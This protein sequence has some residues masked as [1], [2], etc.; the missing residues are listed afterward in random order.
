MRL[1]LV[2]WAFCAAFLAVS[3][4]KRDFG[5]DARIKGGGAMPPEDWDDRMRAPVPL[6]P[7]KTIWDDLGRFIYREAVKEEGYEVECAG[8]REHKVSAERL[9]SGD[10]CKQDAKDS[11][12]RPQARANK[13][14]EK[15]TD[16]RL[17][18][19]NVADGNSDCSFEIKHAEKVAE[20]LFKY[21]FRGT[22]Q[23]HQVQPNDF[24]YDEHSMSLM[25]QVKPLSKLKRFVIIRNRHGNIVSYESV[26]FGNDQV[27]DCRIKNPDSQ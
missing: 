6:S 11:H 1:S 18:G 5:A 19:Q 7:P 8:Y 4:V 23:E 24:F 17:V 2:A 14:F 26:E 20:I 3:C 9:D 12:R 25:A 10:Y 16:L 21:K 15:L 22:T 13:F 27:G